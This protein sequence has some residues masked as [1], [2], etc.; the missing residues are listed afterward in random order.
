MAINQPYRISPIDDYQSQKD[1]Y[2]NVLGSLISGHCYGKAPCP[3][4]QKNLIQ[5]NLSV[6]KLIDLAGGL[7]PLPK[8][9]D[10]PSKGKKSAI[11][12][13]DSA[14][15][16]Q[17][18]GGKLDLIKKLRELK[19]GDLSQV[20]SFLTTD[21]NKRPIA[22]VETDSEVA[23]ITDDLKAI[24]VSFHVESPEDTAN[25]TTKILSTEEVNSL[26]DR[27]KERLKHRPLY[28]GLR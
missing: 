15:Y 11:Y 7:P 4:C 19:F 26:K 9:A 10:T 2:I 16:Y 18:F 28:Y 20:V 6:S 25:T 14:T 21:P 13:D 27:L 17:S 8:K 12:L 1:E 5:F 3:D 24:G 23:K 22:I